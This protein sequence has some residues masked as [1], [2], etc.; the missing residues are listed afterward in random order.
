MCYLV[1]DGK[2][3]CDFRGDSCRADDSAGLCFGANL[4]CFRFTSATGMQARLLHEQIMLR[5]FN[6][7]NCCGP[8]CQ[9]RCWI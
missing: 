5:D 3:D 6:E 9:K 4:H 1:L 2:Q 8:F 7:A